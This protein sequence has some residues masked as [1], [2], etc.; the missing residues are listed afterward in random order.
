[1]PER[2]NR[3]NECF[4]V[5]P[6]GERGTEHFE[7]FRRVLDE[8][9]RPAVERS[10]LNLR[11]VR[12][13]DI[14]RPGSFIRDVVEY[15]ASA[16]TVI[17]DLTGQNANVF[18]E[19]GVRHA[20]SPRTILI[21]RAASDIPADLR[22]YRALI[23]A[24]D[25]RSDAAFRDTLQKYLAEIERAPDEPDNPV[26]TWLKVPRIPGDLAQ[27]FTAR[28]ANAGSTQSELLQFLQKHA[29][30][31]G[32]VAQKQLNDHFKKP[33]PEM[34]YRL[35]QLR[36]LGFITKEGPSA[37][38]GYVY[39]LTPD[40]RKELGFPE[41]TAQLTLV[42][43][44]GTTLPF[45]DGPDAPP[46]HFYYVC[47]RNVRGRR[48]RARTL[49]RRIRIFSLDGTLLDDYASGLQLKWRSRQE[50]C[51]ARW[52]DPG[53]DAI[54]NLGFIIRTHGFFQVD[55]CAD[56]WPDGF[57]GGLN[58]RQR[59]RVDLLADVDDSDE[60]DH[61]SIDITWDGEW[62]DDAVDMEQHLLVRQVAGA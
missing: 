54:A 37:S 8:L 42:S 24:D 19:L 41:V 56:P 26:L 50:R 46:A 17:V 49:L 48:I 55:V 16:H 52:I 39:R 27:T 57:P 11:V 58:A 22:E 30:R 1:M 3:V 23:Y 61:L 4:V 31:H 44:R 47:L 21:A 33:D 25:P 15:L 34:Y 13:D 20:L 62:R 51:V 9:I 59:M 53:G 10:S 60:Q 7:K 38:D 40:F 6:I 12:A 45:G 43:P 36:L 5:S 35:E 32:W 14:H 28:L 2:G 29:R 18:Y